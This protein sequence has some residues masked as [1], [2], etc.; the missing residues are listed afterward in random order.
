MISV[1]E[2]GLLGGL[3]LCSALKKNKSLRHL[4]WRGWF[5]KD[6]ISCFLSTSVFDVSFGA[7]A[8]GRQTASDVSTPRLI[9]HSLRDFLARNN[10]VMGLQA[11]LERGKEEKQVEL[12]RCK[13]LQDEVR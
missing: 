11:K 1:N 10:F 6:M 5:M 3:V 8:G 12:L 13:G 4:H 9:K 2:I 7:C